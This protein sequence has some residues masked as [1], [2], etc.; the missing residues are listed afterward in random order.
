MNNSLIL[1]RI[2]DKLVLLKKVRPF[3]PYLVN[4]LREQFSIEMNYNSNAIEGNT[5]TLQETSQLLFEGRTPRKSLREIN[6][7]INHKKA[8]DCLLK[9]KD[10]PL[11]LPN[12]TL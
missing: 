4:K 11:P 10:S 2:E 7:V 1:K 3:P 6:E 8:F 9:F 5:L 12:A